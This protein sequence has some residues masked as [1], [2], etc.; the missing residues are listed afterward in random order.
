MYKAVWLSIGYKKS[1]EQHCNMFFVTIGGEILFDLYLKTSYLPSA[2]FGLKE[3]L[4]L[5]G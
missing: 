4:R 5:Y 1:V 2:D 3:H